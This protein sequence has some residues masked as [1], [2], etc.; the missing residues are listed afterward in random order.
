M[1]DQGGERVCVKDWESYNFIYIYKIMASETIRF[2]NKG[3]GVRG[4]GS[5][6]FFYL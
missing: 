4:I 2:F 1:G 3:G 6:S 5:R